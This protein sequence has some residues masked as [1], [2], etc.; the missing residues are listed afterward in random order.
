AQIVAAATNAV[1]RVLERKSGPVSDPVAVVDSIGQQLQDALS[2]K[3]KMTI[4][5]SG[6]RTPKP[7]AY[8]ELLTGFEIF[9]L[10]ADV[11]GSRP[12]LRRAIALDSTI[13]QGYALLGRQF[14]NAGEYQA[15]DSVL[16]RLG[17]LNL[18]LTKTEELQL[19]YQR[20]DLDGSIDGMLRNMKG[21]VAL[22]S[23]ALSLFLLGETDLFLLRTRDAI[24]AIRAAEPTFE[25]MGG[26]A[27]LGLELT[28]GTALHV[29]GRHQEGL[30]TLKAHAKNYRG[31]ARLRG[32][33]LRELIGMR[34]SLHAFALIDSMLNENMVPESGTTMGGL[35]SAMGEFRA[36]GDS[37][38]SRHVAT[39][40][41]QRLRQ[42]PD[43][44]NY[45]SFLFDHGATFMMAGL[46]DSAAVAFETAGARSDRIGP[47]G[48]L[49]VARAQMGNTMR[50]RQVADSLGK[51]K[52]PY[53][54]GT[55]TYWRGA[56]LA[57]L[58]DR[59]TAIQLLRQS[60]AE[61]R[62]MDRWHNAPELDALR[63]YP[64]FNQLLKPN[65]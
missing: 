57:A 49:A 41:L 63:G 28:L 25:V 20:A 23:S 58:G 7:E 59:E 31:E 30:Q 17:V 34:D 2:R 64:G 56:I 65:N 9:A 13:V 38:T 4:L 42:T 53:L 32:G 6:F 1:E 22:D 36:H 12:H 16:K 48:F 5:P 37:M 29:E 45:P 60:V 21:L 15:A 50:A 51:L 27:L 19:N 10:N 52:Q 33:V 39:M 26:Q 43:A 47:I 8:K 35:I 61:G 3:T 54:L 55:N 44:F 18:P 40:V 24:E 14:I 46:P 11:F 62:T